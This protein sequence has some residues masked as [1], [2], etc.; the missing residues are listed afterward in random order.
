MEECITR[1]EHEEF[2][3]RIEDEEH[4]QNVRLNNLE[5]QTQTIQS[6]ALAVDRLATSMDRMAKEQTEQGERLKALEREP[7]ESWKSVKK[8]ILTTIASVLAG[9]LA[10]GAII[11]VAQYLR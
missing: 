4:R 8:T 2:A 7:S 5:N 6:L 10:T 1:R 3:H 11:I 9:A